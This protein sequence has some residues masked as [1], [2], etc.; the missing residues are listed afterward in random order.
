MNRLSDTISVMHKG[1]IVESGKTSDII[2]DTKNEYTRNLLK[3]VPQ[4]IN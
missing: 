1:K 2:N 4:I 3:S